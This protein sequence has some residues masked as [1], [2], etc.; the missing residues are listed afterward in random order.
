LRILCIRA[1]PPK[2]IPSSWS[3]SSR[4]GTCLSVFDVLPSQS[5][6]ARCKILKEIWMRTG[7]K[8]TTRLGQELIWKHRTSKQRLCG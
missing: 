1:S 6:T 4:L 7:R 3:C 5:P 2:L 8:R